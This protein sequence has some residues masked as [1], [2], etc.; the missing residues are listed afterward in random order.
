[1]TNILL[2]CV[3]K[4]KESYFTEAIAEYEKRLRKFAKIEIIEVADERI[5]DTPAE[6]DLLKVLDVEGKRLLAKI[7]KDAYVLTLEI[8]GKEM[9][10][11]ELADLITKIGTYESS[12]L[13]FIIGGSLGLSKE[14]KQIAHKALSFS[15]LT[16]PH[17]LMRVVLLEQVYRAFTILNHIAYHK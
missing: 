6:A 10:S 15:K 9:T 1:M 7:P 8:E 12:K 2:L 5:P 11:P 17:Q 14:V 16:F 3:G 13:V 4:I